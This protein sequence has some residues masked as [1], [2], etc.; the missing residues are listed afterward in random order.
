M[1][2]VMLV[3]MPTPGVQVLL[4]SISQSKN[5]GLPSVSCR[6]PCMVTFTVSTVTVQ[7]A[8]WVGSRLEVAVMRHWPGCTPVMTPFS[9]TVAME[10]SE[11]LQVTVRSVAVQGWTKA[12]STA[13]VPRRMLTEFWESWMSETLSVGESQSL[14]AV[15]SGMIRA[16]SW[17]ET[18]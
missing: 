7:L 17:S 6:A 1:A 16:V 2:E 8:E 10:G 18:T 11:E 9:S 4:A 15:F 3:S 14:P 5:M 12:S 13:V